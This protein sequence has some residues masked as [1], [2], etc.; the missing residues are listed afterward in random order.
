MSHAYIRV[1]DAFES[2]SA[3]LFSGLC[4]FT[5][6]GGRH[7]RAMTSIAVIYR[8]NI[9]RGSRGIFDLVCMRGEYAVQEEFFEHYNIG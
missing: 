7:V 6:R 5:R 8:L 2:A 1:I 3:S 4:I 9:A